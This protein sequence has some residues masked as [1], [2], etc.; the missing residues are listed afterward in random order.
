MLRR[1][2]IFSLAA[3]LAWAADS[4]AGVRWAP[5]AS[6]K[7]EPQRPMRLATY[8]VPLA[9]GDS[10]TAE[11][12][13]YYFGQGQGGGVDANLDRWIGQF[14]QPD[15]KPSKSAA[16]IA[17]RSLHGFKVTTVDVS[18]SYT[19]MGG[20]SMQAGAPQPG[21]RLLGAIV[22]GPQGSVFFKFTGPAKTVAQNQPGFEK[23]LDSLASQ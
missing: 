14:A 22:E 13:V 3:A 4:G 12:G 5:P 18:G 2:A 23:M 7:A 6:W 10:G 19:G 8:I 21:Y 1:I 15:G 20:P 17:K 9:S 16:K 11:C